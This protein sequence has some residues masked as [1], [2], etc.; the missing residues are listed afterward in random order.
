VK[1]LSWDNV[2]S[3]QI[4]EIDDDHRKLIDLFN[5][6]INSVEQGDNPDYTRVVFEELIACTAWHFKHEERLM[7]KYQYD[8]FVGH[9]N[10]HNELLESARS[11]QEK[12]IAN[13]QKLSE[14]EI[15]TLENWLTGHILGLDMQLGSYLAEAI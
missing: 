13:D 11:L 9:Q 6:L 3:V 2:L 7:V 4:D 15:L 10:E 12:F 5:M 1:T 14:A 8:G